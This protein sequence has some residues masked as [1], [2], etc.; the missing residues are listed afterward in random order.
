M[1]K[2]ANL[3]DFTL[4]A[5]NSPKANPPPFFSIKATR[6][7]I[8]PHTIIKKAV[9]S[10]NIATC[11]ISAKAGIKLPLCTIIQHK[12][13]ANVRPSTILFV[14]NMKIIINIAGIV[15]NIPKSSGLSGTKNP[16]KMNAANIMP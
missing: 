8:K 11:A 2:R 4:E 7:P 3:G 10:L 16:I 13:V 9:S 5:T 12:I 1:P 15:V 14:L 6:L